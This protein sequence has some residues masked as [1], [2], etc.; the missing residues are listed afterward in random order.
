MIGSMECV[1][2]MDMIGK[3][4][5]SVTVIS[6]VSSFSRSSVDKYEEAGEDGQTG[7]RTSAGEVLPDAF[8]L[9]PALGFRGDCAVLALWL[10]SK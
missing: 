6:L 7:E 5:V 8:V 2:V 10:T 4:I 9:D 3:G 1:G